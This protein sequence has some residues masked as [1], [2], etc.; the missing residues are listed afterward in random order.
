[1]CQFRELR[2][3]GRAGQGSPTWPL[4][5]EPG[6]ANLGQQQGGRPC[7]LLHLILVGQPSIPE[8]HSPLGTSPCPPSSCFH[9]FQ[10]W[11]LAAHIRHALVSPLTLSSAHCHKLSFP[12]PL[13]PSK[14]KE[15]SPD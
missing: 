3:Q 6:W 8:L 15:E 14:S 4:A 12:S 9:R 5:L 13:R 10:F 1:M 11:G 7:P 2:L